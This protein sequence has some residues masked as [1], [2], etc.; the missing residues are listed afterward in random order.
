MGRGNDRV[1]ERRDDDAA[2][3]G[4]AYRRLSPR[5]KQCL[6]LVYDRRVT[7]EIAAELNLGI[8]TVNTYCTEAIAILDAR[9]RRDAAERL[10]AFEA[11]AN[12]APTDPAPVKVQSHSE[13]VHAPRPAAAVL[14][15]EAAT[16]WR[17]LLPLRRKGASSNDLGLLLRLAWIPLLAALG[18][19]A[20]RR[21][22]GRVR[23]S[24]RVISGSR[25]AL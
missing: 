15:T 18:L 9:N 5:H 24:A 16:D 20:R 7:K 1:T 25:R 21:T 6:R 22:T 14:R 11:A 19:I 17:S 12:L 4:D 8:G 23:A 2:A 3:M 10:H 13:G